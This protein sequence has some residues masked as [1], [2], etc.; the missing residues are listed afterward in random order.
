M[1]AGVPLFCCE[2]AER[3]AQNADGLYSLV[4]CCGK[5]EGILNE[6][7]REAKMR[8]TWERVMLILSFYWWMSD[9]MEITTVC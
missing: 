1:Y 7:Q 2:N 4:R 8:D 5:L 3:L 6:K 9:F